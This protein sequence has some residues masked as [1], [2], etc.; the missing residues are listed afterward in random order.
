MTSRL[1]YRCGKAEATRE[2]RGHRV[3]LRCFRHIRRREAAKRQLS[4]FSDVR[5]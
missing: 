4:L 3:C 1:C 5:S 2:I